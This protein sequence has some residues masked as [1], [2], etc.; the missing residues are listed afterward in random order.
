MFVSLLLLAAA[1]PAARAAACR[2]RDGWTDAAP[3]ARIAEGVY[4]VGTCGIT[5]VLVTTP[6]GAVLIDAGPAEAAPLVAANIVRVGVRLQDVRYILSGHEHFDH[7]GGFADLQRRTDAKL[8]VSERAR[9]AIESGTADPADPQFV[10][11]KP[12]KGTPV[13]WTVPDGG[14]VALGGV[15]FTALATPGHSPGATSWTWASCEGGACRTIVYADSLS[16]VSAAGYRFRDHPREVA[17]LRA[18]IAKVRA[19]P[20]DLLLTPHPGASN[21]DARLAG[22]APLADPAGCRRYADA[23]TVAL[24]ARL[25]AEARR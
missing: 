24:D 22:R 3:P 11:L 9:A 1:D 16:A 10:S 19:L 13:A 8:I 2:G 4:D 12:F 17:T 20:C 14:R 21:L 7:A 23:A 5:V 15:T 6:E 25:A 18:S